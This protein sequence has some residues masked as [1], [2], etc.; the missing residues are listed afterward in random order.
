MVL[1]DE[2]KRPL[3]S[4]KR[5][6][7]WKAGCG[8]SACPVWR[9]G[10]RL[11]ALPTPI[12]G[13]RPFW[14][15]DN[16]RRHGH[17]ESLRRVGF[18]AKWGG[19]IQIK[20]MKISLLL[21]ALLGANLVTAV[22]KE[23]PAA[24]VAFISQDRVVKKARALM[25]SGR[26]MAAEDL[27][28]KVDPRASAPDLQA[29]R[30]LD[31]IIQRTRYE[32]SLTFTG[33]VAK[34][35]KSIPDATPAEA[36]HWVKSSRARYRHIDGETFYFRR[37]PQ[38]IFLF[39]EEAIQRRAAAG[40]APAK[41]E[42]SLTDHLAA[43]VRKAEG[44]GESEVL[45]V[46]HHLVHSITIRSNH[47]AIHQGSVVRAWLPFP[48][49][50]RQQQ[51]VRL[52][53][54][55]PP[56]ASTEYGEAQRSIF[57]ELIVT[58]PAAPIRFMEEF[59]YVS[60]A[61]YPKLD[62][63]QVRPLPANWGNTCLTERPPHIVFPPDLR[64]EVAGV[65]G[66][67]RNPL[68]RAQKIFRWVSRNIPWNAEDEYGII[69]SLTRKGF[70]ARRGDCGV[71]NTVFISMCRVA[72]VPARWQSGFETK[73]GGRWGMHDWAEIYI[74]PWGWLPA[75]ASYGEQKSDDP[76]IRDFYCG[77]QDSYRMIVNLDWGQEFFPSKASF[78]SEPAD[79]QR[80]EVEVDGH[81]LYFNEW[82]YDTQLRHD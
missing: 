69:P 13:E 28:R 4:P 60:Y 63:A 36:E 43:V 39:S 23:T 71:Q 14:L 46:K 12:L 75:D 24:S 37:E 1:G 29:R 6:T 16:P 3:P 81:N 59:E 15:N 7:D 53:R 66:E 79:F 20:L 10:G 18:N 44:T 55:E 47:P 38:N 22:A 72:G 49:K 34:L 19:L 70:A 30:E 61:R 58:N 25:A 21:L 35:R 51:D 5:P 74:A 41:P 31:E 17:R 65:V 8:R 77:H 56:A 9:E 27:L 48:Q 80:G 33:L 40:N 50:Y 68:L 67:E 52:I 45:P 11:S 73:P 82:D 42:W 2:A 76:R 64:K 26:F 54:T 62:P 78:R 32:Y 57:F